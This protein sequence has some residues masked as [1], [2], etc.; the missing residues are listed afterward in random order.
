MKNSEKRK[1][2]S[3]VFFNIGTYLATTVAVGGLLA[4]QS[5]SFQ[6]S[7]IALIGAVGCLVVGY[8]IH[9][10]DKEDKKPGGN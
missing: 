1:E 7:S 10:L 5:V 6:I 9:P 2:V 8:I 3:K 4:P